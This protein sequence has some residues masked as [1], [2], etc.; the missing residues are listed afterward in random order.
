V[1]PQ[2]SGDIAAFGLVTSM[3]WL[4]EKYPVLCYITIITITV[5]NFINLISHHT[6]FSP[7]KKDIIMEN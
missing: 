3:L 4:S 1:T 2:K 7:D 6:K 5:I